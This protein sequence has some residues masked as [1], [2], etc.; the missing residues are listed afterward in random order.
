[1]FLG[2]LVWTTVVEHVSKWPRFKWNR[3]VFATP[4]TPWRYHTPHPTSFRR[5]TVSRDQGPGPASDQTKELL[6]T[7]RLR[8]AHKLVSEVAR[9]GRIGRLP[10]PAVAE[11]LTDIVR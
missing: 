8:V 10:Q 4:T 3:I 6:V 5:E 9:N 7:S 2:W 11:R 1:M